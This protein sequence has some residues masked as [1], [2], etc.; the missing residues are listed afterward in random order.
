MG[1]H[2][3]KVIPSLS[4]EEAHKARVAERMAARVREADRL[5]AEFEATLDPRQREMLDPPGVE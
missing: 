3:E 2:Q 4:R 5:A 1:K